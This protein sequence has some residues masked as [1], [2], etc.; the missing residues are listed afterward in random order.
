M[1]NELAGFVRVACLDEVEPGEMRH[2]V[3]DGRHVALAL[4]DGG[5]VAAFNAVCP[6]AMGDLADGLIARGQVI[7]PM[8][9]YR[10]DVRTGECLWPRGE[11]GR[12]TRYTVEIR[13]G[14]VFVNVPR[15]AWW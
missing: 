5:G 11:G 15:P 6:H 9:H 4:L 13:A 7:C 1:S 8:H 3:V 2:V 12:L 14:E 10:Y